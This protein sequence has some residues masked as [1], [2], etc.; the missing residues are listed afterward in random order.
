MRCFTKA[1]NSGIGINF[2][3]IKTYGF[4]FFVKF[5]L[6]LAD[7]LTLFLFTT[8]SK[9]LCHCHF[10]QSPNETNQSSLTLGI[11]FEDQRTSSR[12]GTNNYRSCKNL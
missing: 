6:D 9:L 4:L 12:P 1:D 8:H 5:D 11:R 2:N 10:A 7:N 3:L